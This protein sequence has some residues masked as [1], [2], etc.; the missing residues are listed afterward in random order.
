MAYSKASN[1]KSIKKNSLLGNSSFIHRLV[2]VIS[3]C[4]R[5]KNHTFSYCSAKPLILSPILNIK[6]H[7]GKGLE[8]LKET[9]KRISTYLF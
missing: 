4:I 3:L 8:D 5:K 2:Q 7:A 9:K 1:R 6:S